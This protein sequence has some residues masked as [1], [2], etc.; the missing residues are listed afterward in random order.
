M[1][2]LAR[3]QYSPNPISEGSII[4]ANGAWNRKYA[5]FMRN[6][7]LHA[8]LLGRFY[9]D[10]RAYPAR[11]ARPFKLH[12]DTGERSLAYPTLP[13]SKATGPG[14]FCQYWHVVPSGK[15]KKETILACGPPGRRLSP[16][17]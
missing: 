15:P 8:R 9:A 2:P 3:V 17:L 4:A 12:F 11:K 7:E 5:V 1:H 13:P 16:T 14:G 6:G 10:G